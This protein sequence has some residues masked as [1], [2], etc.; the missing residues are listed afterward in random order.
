[1]ALPEALEQIKTQL[2]NAL[3]RPDVTRQGNRASASVFR[4]G[5]R[6]NI[7]GE[8]VQYVGVNIN[9]PPTQNAVSGSDIEFIT[10]EA[11][12][13]LEWV[14]INHE[15]IG[16]MLVWWVEPPTVQFDYEREAVAYITVPLCTRYPR[17]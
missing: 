11:E 9:R 7:H 10:Q 1:M 12:N 16:E 3:D 4:A 13:F 17:A 2:I 15:D 8:M 14:R 6:T 5:I